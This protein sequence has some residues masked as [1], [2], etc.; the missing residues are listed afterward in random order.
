MRSLDR[1]Q[2]T[3]DNYA[4]FI[5]SNNRPRFKKGAGSAATEVIEHSKQLTTIMYSH[6]R[7]TRLSS[8]PDSSHPETN[9]RNL[10]KLLHRVR[11]KPLTALANWS[12]KVGYCLIE[13]A[14]A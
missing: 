4:T 1:D 7:A 3:K 9:G 14:V 6:A 11:L 13:T 12:D 2:H 8:A 10:S 5:T